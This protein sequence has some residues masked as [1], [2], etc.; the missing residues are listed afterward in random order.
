MTV[1][2]RTR[3]K[4]IKYTVWRM[5]PGPLLSGPNSISASH[6]AKSKAG[7]GRAGG[8]AAATN[9]KAGSG[10]ATKGKPSST[11]SIEALNEDAIAEKLDDVITCA[12][13]HLPSR[14]KLGGRVS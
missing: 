13:M 14:R 9:G 3:A 8:A 2:M 5:R 6:A 10:A 7:A 11:A 4:V 12:N 1:C